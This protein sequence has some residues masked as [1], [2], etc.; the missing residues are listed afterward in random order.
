MVK[1]MRISLLLAASLASFSLAQAQH[2][3]ASAQG[4]VVHVVIE[5]AKGDID[6]DVD[7]VHAPITSANFLHYVDA[8]FYDGGV[9]KRTVRPDNQPMDSVKIGVIQAGIASFFAQA[10]RAPIRLETTKMTGLKHLDGTISMARNLTTGP[11]GDF[12]ICVGDQPGL[13]FGG[14]RIQDHQGFPAFGRVTHGMDVVRAIQASHADL[15]ALNPP[16]AILHIRRA[17]PGK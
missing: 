2:P 17:T 13:D 1:A 3:A 4:G 15:Q 6:L 9:F 11:Q 8:H 5:T 14:H 12:F 10:T 16:I 7:T